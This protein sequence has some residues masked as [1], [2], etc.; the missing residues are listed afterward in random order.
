M[1]IQKQ[2][3]HLLSPMIAVLASYKLKHP[4][5]LPCN[6]LATPW[7]CQQKL[8]SLLSPLTT[9]QSNRIAVVTKP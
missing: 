9:E 3:E 2:S 7:H 6:N 5:N 8:H 1:T 4:K